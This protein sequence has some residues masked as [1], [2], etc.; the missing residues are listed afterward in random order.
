MHLFCY[1][2][3]PQV[4]LQSLYGEGDSNMQIYSKIQK[5]VASKKKKTIPFLWQRDGLVVYPSEN[6]LF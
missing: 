1:V 3:K 6:T 4:R 2:A 5:H